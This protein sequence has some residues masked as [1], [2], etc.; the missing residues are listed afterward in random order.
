MKLRSRI[1]LSVLALVIGLGVALLLPARWTCPPMGYCPVTP[2][3]LNAPFRAVAFVA[4][5]VGSGI[6]AALRTS[7]R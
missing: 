1:A 7:L 3:D 5:L 6:V 2:R 4:G